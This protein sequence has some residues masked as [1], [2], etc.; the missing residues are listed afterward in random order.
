MIPIGSLERLRCLIGS[1][2]IAMLGLASLSYA[3]DPAALCQAK[4][5]KAAGK[6]IEGLFSCHAEAAL[7]GAAVDQGCLSAQDGKLASAF[8]AAEGRAPCVTM[9]DAGTIAQLLDT[10]VAA[11]ATEVRPTTTPASACASSKLRALGRRAKSLYGAYAKQRKPPNDRK[12]LGTT[13]A[14]GPQLEADFQRAEGAG[15]CPTV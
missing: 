14:L 11:M 1:V 12:L 7:Q 13:S 5:L 2:A 3:V 4:K 15:N 6:D 10:S 9:N 8:Q